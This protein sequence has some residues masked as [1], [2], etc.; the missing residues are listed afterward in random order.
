[1]DAN[2]LE[3]I[4]LTKNEITL[5]IALLELGTTTTGPLTKKSELHSSR[6]YESLNKLI[7]KGLVNFVLKANRKY[8]SAADPDTILDILEKEKREIT[9]ILPQLK[10]IKKQK[11]LEEKAA[12]YEGYKGVKSVY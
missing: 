1:M 6:V 9:A 4:G 5:Y 12:I 3:K 7:E 8:F 10:A 11:P 2:V